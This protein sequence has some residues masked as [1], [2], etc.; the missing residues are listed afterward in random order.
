MNNYTTTKTHIDNI[1]HGDVILFDGAPKSVSACNIK[2][3]GFMGTT[4]F[5]DSYKLGTEPVEVV[6]FITAT[7]QKVHCEFTG[8]DAHGNRCHL[9]RLVVGE[10]VKMAEVVK[11]N[12]AA[13]HFMLQHGLVAVGLDHLSPRRE[14][15]SV[16]EAPSQEEIEN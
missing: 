10:R 4:V 14:V 11:G 7:P 9:V 16:E 6:A 1:K 3:G 2:R 5:G 13:N 8:T 12:D 15:W